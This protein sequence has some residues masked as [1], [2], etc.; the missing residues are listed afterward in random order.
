M[1]SPVIR[2]TGR[3]RLYHFRRH[4]ISKLIIASKLMIAPDINK[5]IIVG[6]RREKYEYSVS[7]VT[8]LTCIKFIVRNIAWASYS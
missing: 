4:F 2:P 8:H 7:I 5:N 6:G 1:H 3:V